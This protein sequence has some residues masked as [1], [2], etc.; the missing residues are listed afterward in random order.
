ME[1]QNDQKIIELQNQIGKLLEEKNKEMAKKDE[2]IDELE[3]KNATLEKEIREL[4]EKMTNIIEE[5]E[6]NKQKRK[7]MDDE[8]IAGKKVK[9]KRKILKEFC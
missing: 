6:K 7:M 9:L 2:K 1:Q 8:Q 3:G 4:K 5:N